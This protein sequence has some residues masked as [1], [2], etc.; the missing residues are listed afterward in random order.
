MTMHVA[1]INKKENPTDK[2]L[3]ISVMEGEAKSEEIILSPGEVSR[4]ICIYSDRNLILEEVE[5]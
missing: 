4:D 3:K 2:K 5:N 1:I